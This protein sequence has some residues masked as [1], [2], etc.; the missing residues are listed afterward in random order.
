MMSIDELKKKAAWLRHEA[1]EMVVRAKKGHYPSSA[2]C[3]EIVVALYY[4]GFL[5]YDARN[6]KNPDRDRLFISKGHAG[7]VLY[8]ILEELGFVPKGELLKFTQADG[9]F[10]FYPDPAI[11]GIEAIT[12]SL[13]HGIGLAAGHCLA[14][15]RDRRS[16][17]SYVIISDGECYEGSTWETAMFAAHAALDNLMVFVDRNGCCIMDHTEKCVRLDPLEEKWKAFGWHTLSIDA[18][19]LPEVIG[20]LE[21]AASG[22]ITRPIAVIA[23]SVKGKGVSFMENQPGWHNRMPNEAEILQARRELALQPA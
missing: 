2:S 12:G 17:R 18:H 19:S 22:K 21:L 1:F 5:R 7:M 8:P 14:A 6:P 23:R 3:T 20:A 11:P 13:G 10:K 15:K 9:I 16:F 4:G